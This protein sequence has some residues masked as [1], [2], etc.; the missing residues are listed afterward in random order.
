VAFASA[1]T[2]AGRLHSFGMQHAVYKCPETEIMVLTG[3]HYADAQF[4]EITRG[5]VRL[6]CPLC[7]R[8][9]IVPLR[10]RR[11]NQPLTQQAHTAQ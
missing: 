3:L 2:R 9:H 1:G 6:D 10:R 4:E 5:P 7:R 11:S 8:M